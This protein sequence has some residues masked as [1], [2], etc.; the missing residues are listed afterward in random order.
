[1]EITG[2][3]EGASDGEYSMKCADGTEFTVKRMLKLRRE[4]GPRY[5]DY[6]HPELN[7]VTGEKGLSYKDFGRGTMFIARNFEEIHTVVETACT[8]VE[9]SSNH[10]PAVSDI[11]EDFELRFMRPVI[12]VECLDGKSNE[13]RYL[14][15]GFEYSDGTDTVDYD[16]ELEIFLAERQYVDNVRHG[17]IDAALSDALLEKYGPSQLKTKLMKSEYS[18]MRAKNRGENFPVGKTETLYYLLDYTETQK[19]ETLDFPWIA[20]WAECTGFMPYAADTESYTLARGDEKVV[21][22]FSESE[23]YTERDGVRIELGGK[24]EWS[25]I[26]SAIY[27]TTGDLTKLFDSE[28]KFDYINGTAEIT[29]T[30]T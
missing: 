1:M 10:I 22:H 17:D 3:P 2:A 26:T 5:Y 20:S 27:L 9:D 19:H 8:L 28:L 6:N 14:W 12:Q 24:M 18:L 13:P 25:K 21:F 23:C 16:E 15:A 29:N 30:K 4:F 11:D 7:T